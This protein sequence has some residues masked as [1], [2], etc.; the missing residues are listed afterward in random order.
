MM[1]NSYAEVNLAAIRAN[2]AALRQQL[3]GDITIIAVVKANGYGHGAVEVSRALLEAGADMLAVALPAEGVELRR[4]GFTCPILVMGSMLGREVPLALEHNLMVTVFSEPFAY[5][6]A[7]QAQAHNL[8]CPVH[9]KVDTG[10]GRLGLPAAEAHEAVPRIARLAGLE[11]VGL[12]TH[13]ASAEEEDRTFTYHQVGLFRSVLTACQSAGLTFRYIHTANSAGILNIPEARF[14]T[15]RPGIILYGLSP[16]EHLLAPL[17]LTPALA[18]K[19]V[20]TA[21][22]KVPAGTPLSYGRTFTTG[23]PSL[24]GCVPVG[25][26]DGYCRA[27][28]GRALVGVRSSFAPVVGRVC[29]DQLL[30]DVTD[31]PDAAVGD[32]VVLYSAQADHP[33]S[34][35]AIARLLGTIPYEVVTTITARVPRVYL[36]P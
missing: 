21:V 14:N 29:M 10:M 23:R 6:V 7:S 5:E 31:V 2:M 1:R 11:V 30:V 3:A 19:S 16:G 26:A 22:R 28:S 24:I 27:L 32:E 35:E 36:N 15:V 4:A 17:P 12:A 9:V 13:F 25:Y 18:L 20:L 8:R 33:N 34:V